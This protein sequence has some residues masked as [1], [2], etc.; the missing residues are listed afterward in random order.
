MQ[1]FTEQFTKKLLNIYKGSELSTIIRYYPNYRS[2]Y[3]Y[4]T[5]AWM[6]FYQAN[7]GAVTFNYH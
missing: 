7:W 4:V 5:I 6:S 3:I 1:K 2:G